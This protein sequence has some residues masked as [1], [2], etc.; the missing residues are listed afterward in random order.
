MGDAFSIVTNP[1]VALSFF[2]LSLLDCFLLV[3]YK[4]FEASKE[5]KLL[6]NSAYL[7]VLRGIWLKRNARIFRRKRGL[8]NHLWERTIFWG[9]AFLSVNGDDCACLQGLGR[10]WN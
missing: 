7:A 6:W 2:H 3:N 10:P 5:D 4:G 1:K 8:V 9:S